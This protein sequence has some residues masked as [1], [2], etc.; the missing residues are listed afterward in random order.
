MNSPFV[1]FWQCLVAFIS[2]RR[3]SPLVEQLII[4]AVG[5]L[6]L[7]ILLGFVTGVFDWIFEVG[8]DAISIFRDLL[9]VF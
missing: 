3:A 6:I 9:P 2:D 4:I 8:D 5:F 1:A 7:L